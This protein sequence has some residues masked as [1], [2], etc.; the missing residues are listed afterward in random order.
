MVAMSD[1]TSA[2]VDLDVTETETIE[3][4]TTWIKLD[5][6]F[7]RLCHWGGTEENGRESFPRCFITDD[8]NRPYIVAC[9]VNLT[10]R[11]QT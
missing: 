3:A 2:T 4:R 8:E 11:S 9:Q 5:G 1:S 6:N 7:M 10:S